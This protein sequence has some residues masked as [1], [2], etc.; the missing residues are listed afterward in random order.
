MKHNFL[1]HKESCRQG[2]QEA[3][4]NKRKRKKII[5]PKKNKK[6]MVMNDSY[7]ITLFKSNYVQQSMPLKRKDATSD[8][9]FIYSE[10]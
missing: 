9:S 3:H 1:N 8:T 4:L 7:P 6:T 10:T 2:G 5:N